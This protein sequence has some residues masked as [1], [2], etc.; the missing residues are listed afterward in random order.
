MKNYY[1]I[2]VDRSTLAT[3]IEGVKMDA[4]IEGR[5]FLKERVK[6]DKPIL[7]EECQNVVKRS[8][9]DTAAYAGLAAPIRDVQRVLN[10]TVE[11]AEG[12]GVLKDKIIGE[13]W[14]KETV[15][16]INDLLTDLQTTRRKRSSTMSRALDRMRGNYAGAILTVNPGVPKSSASGS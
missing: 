2:A 6:S 1:P 9:R 13:K 15:N 8:L 3:E 7:L 16:Y 10:S 4:T 5:G 12:I 11:T 14:G